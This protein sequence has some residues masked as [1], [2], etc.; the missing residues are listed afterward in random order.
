MI[1]ILFADGGIGGL[2]FLLIVIIQVIASILNKANQKK[3]VETEDAP[4]EMPDWMKS[5]FEEEDAEDTEEPATPPPERHRE[6]RPAEPQPTRAHEE[7]PDGTSTMEGYSLEHIPG[8]TSLG[9]DLKEM[10]ADLREK[11]RRLPRS[12]HL[13]VTPAPPQP[14]IPPVQHEPVA[15]ASSLAQMLSTTDQLRNAV[16]VAEVLGPCKA[17]RRWR[18]KVTHHTI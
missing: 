3:Q 7:V 15:A 8:K 16:M 11:E 1:D 17:K 18:S 9:D 14:A 4:P 13:E 12:V 5:W 6:I 2:I 10:F